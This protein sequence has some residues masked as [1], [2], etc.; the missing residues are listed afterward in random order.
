MA[1]YSTQTTIDYLPRISPFSYEPLPDLHHLPSTIASTGAYSF[2]KRFSNFLLFQ[3]FP[4]THLPS[5]VEQGHMLFY[6]LSM[7]WIDWCVFSWNP[8]KPSFQSIADHLLYKFLFCIL[9]VLLEE[10]FLVQGNCTLCQI[11]LML[12]VSTLMGVM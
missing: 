3:R 2:V 11:A 8:L 4:C 9:F 1:P 7:P 6:N 10:F 12:K 5:Y